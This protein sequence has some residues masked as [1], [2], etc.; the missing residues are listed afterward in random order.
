LATKASVREIVDGQQRLRAI[1]RFASDELVLDKRAKEFRG[2]TYSTLSPELQETFLSYTI[3][4]EQLINA[5]N[6]DV[7]EVFARLNSYTVSLNDAEKRHAE[8]QGDF[9]WAV[10]EAA[11]RWSVLWDKFQLL[12]VRQR[13]RMLDD[14]LMAEM[15]GI[16]LEGVKDGG[17]RN[18]KRL[19]EKY[20]ATFS[21][22]DIIIDRLDKTLSFISEKLADAI[23]GPVSRAPHFLMLYTGVAHALFGIPVGEMDNAM[24]SKDNKALSNVPIALENIAR[25]SAIIETE[26]PSKKWLEFWHAS[27][28]TTQRI[29]S[30]KVRFPIYYKA[31]LPERL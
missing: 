20:D 16:L 7:L 19:Y 10:H 29:A 4:V 5:S 17:Q 25:L 8:F 3:G 21:D 15:F 30:R 24:P 23:E 6:D 31:L 28:G 27:S 11:T 14:S 9:K 26:E 18:I 2:L 1:F 12:S 22:Q 13:L